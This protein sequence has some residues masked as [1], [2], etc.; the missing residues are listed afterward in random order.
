MH[1]VDRHTFADIFKKRDATTFRDK[2]LKMS[3][4]GYLILTI[5][6]FLTLDMSLA[7]YQATRP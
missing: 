4:L 5:K 7:I 3:A 1:Q 6:V 2:E